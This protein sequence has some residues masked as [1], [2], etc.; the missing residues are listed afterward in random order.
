MEQF[1]FQVAEIR[2]CVGGIPP[3]S[4]RSPPAIDGAPEA[5]AQKSEEREEYGKKPNLPQI[6]NNI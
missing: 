2:P 4:R 3:P 5:P 6:E 1:V